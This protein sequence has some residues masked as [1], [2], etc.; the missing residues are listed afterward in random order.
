MFLNGERGKRKLNLALGAL[1]Q[2]WGGG[3]GVDIS[4][5]KLLLLRWHLFPAGTTFLARVLPTQFSIDFAEKSLNNLFNRNSTSLRFVHGARKALKK[6]A[7]A[8]TDC[9]RKTTYVH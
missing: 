5:D 4:R 8:L 9:W 2:C 7:D 1:K 3:G 6:A